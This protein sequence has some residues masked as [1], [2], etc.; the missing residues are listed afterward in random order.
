MGNDPSIEDRVVRRE[1]VRFNAG[2]VSARL[3]QDW[4]KSESKLPVPIRAASSIARTAAAYGLSLLAYLSPSW[5]VQRR[6]LTATAAVST[7]VLARWNFWNMKAQNTP[8]S[9]AFS[10]RITGWF[11]THCFSKVEVYGLDEKVMEHYRR[12]G[13]E[14][15]PHHSYFD[16]SQPFLLFP[17]K[18]ANSGFIHVNPPDSTSPEIINAE[19]VADFYTIAGNNVANTPIFGLLISLWLRNSGAVF[20]PRNSYGKVQ[21]I[22]GAVQNS[23]AESLLELGNVLRVFA[24]KGRHKDGIMGEFNPWIS[25]VA[26]AHNIPIQLVYTT[27]EF[28]PEDT[29]FVMSGKKAGKPILEVI[30]SIFGTILSGESRYGKIHV[31]YGKQIWPEQVLAEVE[32]I[33]R[34]RLSAENNPKAMVRK[35]FEAEVTRQLRMLA[36]VTPI[37]ALCAAIQGYG[38]PMLSREEAVGYAKELVGKAVVA[39]VNVDPDLKGAGIETL[40]YSA[41]DRLF[42]RGAFK[43]F[44]NWLIPVRPAGG[45]GLVEFYYN[46]IWP[47]LKEYGINYQQSK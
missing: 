14:A 44:D 6:L 31:N 10:E 17:S 21:R 36:T 13:I 18:P 23:Y 45:L 24:G 15:V 4:Q 42:K 27:Y 41:A 20:V 2:K 25:E 32:P 1:L 30:L 39:G 40:L 7:E 33:A 26:I 5:A 19:G 16:V 35:L 43:G 28:I 22:A 38:K 9:N 12:G 47:A 37:N 34:S 3:P 29:A 11:A 8:L 46:T